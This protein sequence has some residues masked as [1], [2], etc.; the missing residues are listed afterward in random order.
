MAAGGAIVSG[1]QAWSFS[2]DARAAH[3]AN[4]L[5][6]RMGIGVEPEWVGGDTT[7]D[8]ATLPSLDKS[9]EHR[10]ACLDNTCAGP[11]GSH[12]QAGGTQALLQRLA[13]WLS[14]A[15]PL[16]AR[17][18]PSALSLRAC[19]ARIPIQ[20]PAGAAASRT[21]RA[22]TLLRATLMRPKT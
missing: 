13:G 8:A 11:A 6:S 12:A 1:A 16:Y 10:L 21:P 3:P 19:S 22:S 2:G 9:A 18:L 5:F 4:Q 14:A 15:H 20:K 7:V 17:L